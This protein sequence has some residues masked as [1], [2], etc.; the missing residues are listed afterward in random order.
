MSVGLTEQHNVFS[1]GG[2]G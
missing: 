1:H 2:K